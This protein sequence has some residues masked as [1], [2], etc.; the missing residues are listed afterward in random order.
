[1]QH[2]RRN[3]R[4]PIRTN[5]TGPRSGVTTEEDSPMLRSLLIL[6]SLATLNPQLIA[7]LAPLAPEARAFDFWVGEWDVQNRFFRGGQWVAGGQAS[8]RVESA[9][10]GAAIVEHWKG[11][12]GNKER[13][14]FS[15]RCWDGDLQRWV[16]ILSWPSGP[17]DG[18]FG[19]LEG[20]FRH[21][22]GEFFAGQGAQKSRYSFSDIHPQRFR[23]DSASTKDKGKTWATDWIMEFSRRKEDAP[24]LT[25]GPSESRA[26]S[27]SAEA[28]SLD[29]WLGSWTGQATL[30]TEFDEVIETT[31]SLN[32]ELILEGLALTESL[33]LEGKQGF[34][35]Y[36][37]FAFDSAKGAWTRYLVDRR[38]PCVE[39]L[40]GEGTSKSLSWTADL[41]KDLSA[42]ESWTL[43]GD[44]LRIRR[45]NKED[46]D[47]ERL[48]LD[49]R[50]KRR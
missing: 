26:L 27:S 6:L 50:L 5:A 13:L 46:D 16:L 12:T 24:A 8:C 42:R 4:L 2:M 1:M 44:E 18:G 14:G 47:D 32:C 20:S 11:F 23:W 15:L 22:R 39:R 17:D 35:R 48:V 9:A 21:G 19:R 33:E 43:E 38:D 29:P 45:W 37:V 34:E 28:R 36:S 49:L 7:Q 31:A 25:Q 30:R 40:A 41:R 3:L 10:Q